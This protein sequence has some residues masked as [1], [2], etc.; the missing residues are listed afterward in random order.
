[1]QVHILT[2]KCGDETLDAD[3]VPAFAVSGQ[4]DSSQ[5][6]I[7]SIP[8]PLV[9]G[10]GTTK[11]HLRRAQQLA[12]LAQLALR[13]AVHLAPDFPAGKIDGSMIEFR[14]RSGDAAHLACRHDAQILSGLIDATPESEPIF[15]VGGQLAKRLA[16]ID[17][18]QDRI[19]SLP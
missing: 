3:R 17:H 18:R 5:G 16:T 4:D 8:E 10:F 14:H 9:Q 6:P 1:M 11:L 7:R 19:A 15:R 2:I 12:V 13:G